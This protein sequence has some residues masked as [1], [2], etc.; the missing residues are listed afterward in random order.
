M[1]AMIGTGADRHPDRLAENG[2]DCFSHVQS[3]IFWFLLRWFM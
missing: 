2:T 3:P 1:T